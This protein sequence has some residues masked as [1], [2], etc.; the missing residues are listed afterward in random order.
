MSSNK[1]FFLNFLI[2]GF[3]K[4][5]K[6]IKKNKNSTYAVFI[7]NTI[8]SDGITN[9]FYL[10]LLVLHVGPGWHPRELRTFFTLIV[11]NST[12]LKRFHKTVRILCTAGERPFVGQ[13][14]HR[15]ILFSPIRALIT[16]T[17]HT[18]YNSRSNKFYSRKELY[19]IL[20]TELNAKQ[21][22]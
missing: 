13:L 18:L 15:F 17:L 21:L 2:Q 19:I 6:K 8:D 3:H 12:Y 14:C 20:L 16:N 7:Q 10:Y 22:P 4:K 11:L 9:I 5:T 1:H